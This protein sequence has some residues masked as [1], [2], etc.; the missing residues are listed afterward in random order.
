MYILS[1]LGSVP[2]FEGLNHS[3]LRAL[4][5]IAY[6][7]PCERGDRLIT[8]GEY[9]SHFFIIKEGR[10]VLTVMLSGGGRTVETTIE[11]KTSKEALGWSA[12]VTPRNSIYSVYCVRPGHVIQFRR[13]DLEHLMSAKP[14]LGYTLMRNITGLVGHRATVLQDLWLEEVEQSP[15]RVKYWMQRD[16]KF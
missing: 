7:R 5:E 8:R 16:V 2:V 1:N 13:S 3:D 4:N 15:A 6:E 11:A 12:L 9:A 10:F 14:A